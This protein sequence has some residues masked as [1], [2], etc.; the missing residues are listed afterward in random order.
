MGSWRCV[1]GMKGDGAQ[2]AFDAVSGGNAFAAATSF[3]SLSSSANRHH[4][5]STTIMEKSD[6]P[7]H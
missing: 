6:V 4:R 3:R 5:L 2:L 1:G 7:W